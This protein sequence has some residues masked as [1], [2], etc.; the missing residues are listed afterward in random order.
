MKMKKKQTTSHKV[1]LI[2][3]LCGANFKVIHYL[4][5]SKFLILRSASHSCVVI[6]IRVTNGII[7]AIIRWAS[8]S[9]CSAAYGMVVVTS[10]ETKNAT[11]SICP[12]MHSSIWKGRKAKMSFESR[13]INHWRPQTSLCSPTQPSPVQAASQLDWVA[14]LQLVK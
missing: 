11:L 2:T 4:T 8:N 6:I 3:L 13:G 5:S 14:L 9:D 1:K 12:S 7:V 10:S